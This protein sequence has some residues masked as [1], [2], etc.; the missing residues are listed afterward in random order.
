V[1]SSDNPRGEDPAAIVAEILAGTREVDPR[2]ARV[3]VE[4]DRAAA[5]ALAI[6]RAGPGD[7]VLIAG[8]GHEPYQLVAGVRHD[9]DD[10]LVAGAA[11]RARRSRSG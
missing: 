4:V 8:K 5:I 1:V 2:G 7:I 9:F 11:L 3:V 10:R 6:D